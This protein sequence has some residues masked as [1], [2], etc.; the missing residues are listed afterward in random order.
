M[1]TASDTVGLRVGR[2]ALGSRPGAWPAPSGPHPG[3][4]ELIYDFLGAWREADARAALADIWNVP[5]FAGVHLPPPIDWSADPCR[6]KYWRFQ[7]LSLRPARSLLGAFLASGDLRCRDKLLETLADFTTHTPAAPDDTPL[8]QALFDPHTAAFRALLLVRYYFAL[9][10]CGA[11]PATLAARLRVHIGGLGEFLGGVRGYEPVSN[12]AITE[13]A[14][15]Y[16][17]SV[18]FANWA[19]A[20][21]WRELALARWQQLLLDIVDDDGAQREQSPGYHFYVLD[22]LTQLAAWA[23]RYELPTPPNLAA[24]LAQ[25]EAFGAALL[26][27]DGALPALGATINAAPL[28]RA[29]PALCAAARDPGL[30]W[31]VS[32]GTRGAP[33]LAS[34]QLFPTA[35][36]AIL[37]S[38]ID[39]PAALA[40]SAHVVFDVGPFRSAHSDLD[41]LS[42]H[43]YGAGRRLLVDAGFYSLERGPWRD[44]FHGTRGHNTVVVDDRN[45]ARGAAT[46]RHFAARPGL[47]GVIGVSDLYRGVTHVRTVALIGAELLIVMDELRATRKRCFD[48]R[49]HLDGALRAEPRPGGARAVDAH[50]VARVQIAQACGG[51]FRVV[52]GQEAPRDGWIADGSERA[53]PA[54]VVSFRQTGCA[55]RFVTVFAFGSRAYAKISARFCGTLEDGELSVRCNHERF[56]LSLPCLELHT[57]WLDRLSATIRRRV[58]ASWRPRA[59]RGD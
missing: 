46:A 58:A 6:K 31:L 45:Q 44:Y 57:R 18:E 13:M 34:A 49:W 5:R 26:Q 35:G 52:R 9:H 54:D 10:A 43:L 48:Q 38:P 30:L 12:H 40:R 28:G 19:P 14:A 17:I 3:G 50:G 22:F 42:V 56:V 55:A 33:P 59:A 8:S 27:P 1:P 39:T 23:A 7:F 41:A 29:R 15:L 21:R 20:T 53:V 4:R 32:G 11:L 47:A 2:P 16:L 25:M 36:F 51:V 37:R 24:R